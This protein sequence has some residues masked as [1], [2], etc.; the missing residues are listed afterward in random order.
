[1]GQT[2]SVAAV[3]TATSYIWTLPAGASITGG[4]NTNNITAN[5]S[6]VASGVYTYSVEA[7]NSCGSGT[8]STSSFSVSAAPT[9]SVSSGAICIGSSFTIAPS[10]ASTY[11]VSGG[12]SV[13]S[14]TATT[15]YSVTGLSAVGCASSNTAIATVSVNSLPVVTATANANSICLGGTVSLN[16]GGATTYGWSNGIT[17]NVSFSP[18]TTIT[19]TVTGT[20]GNGCQNTAI[21]TVTVNP[22]PAVTATSSSNAICIGGTVT[23][24]GNGATTY[25]WSNGVTNNVAFSPTTT[26]TY[27]VTGTDANGCQNTAVRTVTVN[28][29]PIVTATSSSNAICIGGTVTLNGI[30][31]TTYGW[32][33]SVTNNVSFSPT[34]TL[35]YTVTGT[36]GNGCQNTAFRTV[37]VNP[38]PVVTATSSTNSVCNG[39]TVTLNG[40]GATTYNWSNSVTNNVAFSPSTTLTYTVTGTDGNGCQNTA[41]R[42]V[43]VNPLP[44]VTATSSSNAI[45]IG[46]TVTLNGNGATTY[47][48]S[49]GVTN[50]VA[51]SPTTTLT[52]T[53]TGTDGNGCQNTATRVITVNLLP[54]VTA[55]SSSNAVCIGGTVTLNGIGATTYGW[56]NSVTNN[57]AFS[58]VSTINYTVT[59]TDGNGCQ[60]TAFR[61]VS[62]NPLPIVTAT[63]NANSVCNGATVTLNGN[64]ATTYNWSNSV[65]NNVA[66]S[67][68][69]TLTYT[70]TGTDGNG[71]QNTAV[72]TVTVNP[73]PAVTATSSSNA[74]CIGGTVTLNGNGATTYGWSNGVTNNVA[75]SPTTTLTYTVTGTD[76][77]GCQNTAVRT[78]TVNPLPVVTAT[79][80]S[81][82]LCI[83]GTVTLN[84]IGATTYGWSNGVTNNVAFSPVST[85]NY[86]VTGTDG[87]G[88][89]NTAFRTVSVNPLP[90]VTATSSTNSICIG[91]TVSLNGIGATTYSWSNGVTNNLAFSPTTTLTYTVTGTD[92]NGCQNTATRLITVNSLPA[93]LTLASNNPICIG[94]SSSLFGGGAL[95]YTWSTSQIAVGITVTPV[96]SGITSYSV[97]GSNGICS[98]TAAISITINPLPIVT[99]SASS[100]AICIG[101]TVS[102]SGSGATSYSWS[103]GVTNNSAFSPTSTI[104]YTVT[105]SDGNGCQNTASRTVSVNPLPVVTATSS[106]NSICNGGTVTLNG[107]GATTYNWSN[108]VTNNVAFS[109]TTTLTYTVTGTDGNGCQN[110]AIRIITVNALPTVSGSASNPVICNGGTTTLNGSGA[111]TYSWTGGI[112]NGLAFSPTN[113][114]S[115]SLT[116]ISIA[117]CTSTNVAVTSVT[118]NPLPIVT[119]NS[120]SI[121]SGNNFTISPVGGST[122]VITGGLFVVS[123]TITTN[124]SVS[125]SSTAGCTSAS[126]AVA[127]VSVFARPIVSVANGTICTGNSFTVNPAL[128][129]GTATSYTYVG[130]TSTITSGSLIVTPTITSTYSIT[131]TDNFG[132]ESTNTAVATVTVRPRPVISA[133]SGAVCLGS[134][135][136]HS[137]T[138]ATSYIFSSGGLTVSPSTT[139]TYSIAG[140]NAFGCL[141]SSPAIVNV[142]VNPLPNVII[143]G[144]GSVC[145]GS[146]VTLTASGASTYYW[147]GPTGSVIV[148]N[149]TVNTVYNV[150]GTDSNNCNGLA[151]ISVSVIPSPSI[152]ANSGVIC[153]GDTY[154]IVPTGASTYTYSGGSPL[155]SPTIT[156]TYSIVGTN[157]L[158]CNAILPAVVTVSVVNSLTITIT[159]NSTVC[160]GETVSLT[161]NGAPSYTWSGGAGTFSTIVLTPTANVSY[162]LVGS[163]AACTSSTNILVVA[164]PL[165]TITAI[166]S[167]SIICI[168]ESASLTVSGGT[169]YT[170][171]PNGANTSQIVVTPTASSTYSVLG[172][173]VNGCKNTNTVS[174][175]VAS[176]IGIPKINSSLSFNLYPNPNNGEFKI[177]AEQEM[178]LIL[179]NSLGEVVL[180]RHISSGENQISLKDCAKGLYF[181]KLSTTNSSKT[182]KVVKQ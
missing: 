41:V 141:S 33:N 50:N 122:Y 116:G 142:T 37:S 88:C 169:T 104:N 182:I 83:G 100:N 124:Y 77:N 178:D 108:S 166:A 21:R 179:H 126:P 155:V 16:G 67:P 162:T 131:G 23:L 56:S 9:V 115:Y 89:Q 87:N 55:T 146:S 157:S 19:Y 32:S 66:F 42:T 22:L 158:G 154:T 109:P 76:A 143:N 6:G 59:G 152:V 137:L 134:T 159:G 48:W 173:D 8:A 58:P 103:N 13:V 175:I 53:V 15:N 72:R 114:A 51:F 74:I 14:P 163:S 46:G 30:G 136:T 150:I 149:P 119:V 68:S 125:A 156:T 102:L 127:T 28:P 73:L 93:I 70:V 63:S 167:A 97:T 176:C 7:V 138:G 39:A 132:C 161:A 52:Y 98:N 11:S 94:G 20:D 29:L 69:T 92:V 12:S 81:N 82:A 110:T 90:V 177:D 25:G 35:T 64:G 174:V 79:S 60:N 171:S 107:I 170:W 84:G 112:T 38:L 65:T 62:V 3:A 49:N 86:T 17:N 118:V 165:P 34:T 99:A 139:T 120:G 133:T 117:G 31:A 113:T 106:A 1:V 71:C 4:N 43:T 57:V 45:C 36:D 111:N 180:T 144:T 153:I 44:A 123:P 95:T 101:G 128:N 147:G 47:G 130:A 145:A 105:A 5:F 168:N 61:T 75:F 181:A 40:N 2:F 54:V 135:F 129:F 80:S 18:T 26:L 91:S 85:I 96:A 78:V 27:T 151:A 172:Q 24:N 148:V 140:T 121:C 160:A 10:G 164:N